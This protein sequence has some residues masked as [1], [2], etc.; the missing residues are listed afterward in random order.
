M[1]NLYTPYTH[2]LEAC[3]QNNSLRHLV[4]L[5]RLDKNRNKSSRFITVDNRQYINLSSNDY[6]GLSCHPLLS[7]RA[8]EWAQKYG[9]GSGSSR[10]VT[11][12]LSLFDRVEKKISVLK[13]KPAALVMGSGFQTNASI[14]QALLD[15]S[16][17][18]QTPL[19][20]SDRLNH[21]SIHFGCA[22]A[23]IRQIRYHHCDMF[24][25]KILLEKYSPSDQPKFIITESIFSM[26][27]DH[28]PLDKIYKLAKEYNAIVIIDDAHSI[29]KNDRT[30][31]SQDQPSIIIGTFSKA[32]GSYGSYV[33]ADHIIIDFLKNHC[34]GLIYST[35]LPPPILGAIDAALDLIQD[36]QP[37][38]KHLHSL[39][40]TLRNELTKEGLNT[41]K[42]T[43]QIIPLIIG[44]NQKAIGLSEALRENHFW[45]TAIRPPTVPKNTARI[46]L[47][48]SAALTGQDIE[49]LLETL[50]QKNWITKG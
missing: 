20:F 16:V 1:T 40:M 31:P 14:I 8:A 2:F 4:S 30:R 48:L 5:D 41:G 13:Q 32:F 38:R 15:S 7:K 19:V 39:S 34:K 45:V 3:S 12:N 21:A 26:D 47:S 46:R 25:L 17:L 18:K 11:G 49:K 35:A 44:D 29:G 33:T 24:H 27:G 28:A 50:A 10:L 9:T 23:G 22:A 36:M 42:S 6:L 37:E 43:S